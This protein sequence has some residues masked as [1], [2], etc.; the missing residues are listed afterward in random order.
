MKMK[1][2]TIYKG[3]EISLKLIEGKI[4]KK[5]IKKEI[6]VFPKTVAILPFLKK[7]K[8]VLVRQYR[9]PAKKE[10]WEIP[11]GKLERGERPEMGAK[12]ELKEETGF[13]ARK[14]EKI[15]EFYLTPG[16]S[17][18][19]MYLFRA[20]ILKEKKQILNE[21]ELIKNVRVFSKKEILEMIKNK[22]IIDA[23]TILAISLK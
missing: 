12:R 11:A 3:R 16:Y 9:F 13:L 18:E 6:V 20:A 22:K 15:S 19:Y 5:E 4:E 21:G 14:L 23:K 10:L 8:I 1:G 7:D 2:T 17:T